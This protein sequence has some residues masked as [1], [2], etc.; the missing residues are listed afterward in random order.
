MITRTHFFRT[1]PLVAT[2][3]LVVVV[4]GACGGGNKDAN[5]AANGS[6]SAFN[7]PPPGGYPPGTGPVTSNGG[8]PNMGYP[9][10]GAPN[11]GYPPPNN[12]YPPPNNGTPPQASA[13]A[14]AGLPGLPL[15]QNLLAQLAAAGSAMM[16]GGAIPMG[17]PVE[18][19][20]KTTSMTAAPGMQPDGASVKDT[21]TP[22]GHKSVLVTLQGGK[23]YTFIAFSPPGQVT[24]VDLHLL[25]PP[26]Y[27]ME[28][29]HDDNNTNTA[30]IGRGNAP[31]CPFTPFPVQYK[32]DVHAKGGQGA[33]GVQMFSKT[34]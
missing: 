32:L 21:L 33:I 1:L 2:T 6:A 29:G 3:A 19:G 16:G 27:N 25:T 34:K 7:Q 9:N 24:N 31:L 13:S 14:S 15:D 17:D 11:N 12:G 22:D 5:T 20:I 4:A 28:A 23:C 30:V 8:N 18:L 10:N 26:F